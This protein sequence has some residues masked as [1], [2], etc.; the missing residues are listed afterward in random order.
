MAGRL[1]RASFGVVGVAGI[2]AAL[3]GVVAGAGLLS[4]F[5]MP[6]VG[7]LVFGK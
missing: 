1:R 4:D 5:E 2:L 6:T 3:G 7:R